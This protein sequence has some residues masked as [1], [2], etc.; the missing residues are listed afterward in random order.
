[1]H[2][3]PLTVPTVN[4][5]QLPP[6]RPYHTSAKAAGLSATTGNTIDVD[7]VVMGT[8]SQVQPIY[9]E[10]YSDKEEP[11]QDPGPGWGWL[12]PGL[13]RTTESCSLPSVTSDTISLVSVSKTNHLKG[14]KEGS[15]K[16]GCEPTPREALSKESA[17]RQNVRLWYL[18][19]G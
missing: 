13:Y 7:H 18:E 5:S 3:T 11:E 4:K 14:R 15:K 8:N 10:T 19:G 1:M 12:P 17:R 2:Q 6:Q 16:A 9:K